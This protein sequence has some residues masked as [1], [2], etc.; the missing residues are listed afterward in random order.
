MFPFVPF[1]ANVINSHV[2]YVFRR[3][4]LPVKEEEVQ[5]LVNGVSLPGMKGAE[6]EPEQK[7]WPVAP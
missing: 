5:Q 6:E 4:G 3:T 2:F 1:S 7:I